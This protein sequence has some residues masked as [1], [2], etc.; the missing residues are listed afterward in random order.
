MIIRQGAHTVKV[1]DVSVRHFTFSSKRI[2]L[3]YYLT[4]YKRVV[5]DYIFYFSLETLYTKSIQNDLHK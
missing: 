1:H 3:S 5:E 2:R 4:D